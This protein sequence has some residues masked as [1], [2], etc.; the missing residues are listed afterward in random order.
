MFTIKCKQYFVFVVAYSNI[1]GL[2]GLCGSLI[3]YIETKSVARGY[4]VNS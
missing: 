1:F 2:K 4:E 3:N